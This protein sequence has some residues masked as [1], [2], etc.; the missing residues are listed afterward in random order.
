MSKWDEINFLFESLLI[1]FRRRRRFYTSHSRAD[2]HLGAS[3]MFF[4][5]VV[6]SRQSKYLYDCLQTDKRAS[7]GRLK[8]NTEKQNKYRE[9]TVAHTHATHQCRPNVEWKSS[10]RAAQ[11]LHGDKTYLHVLL[12]QRYA[13]WEMV[14]SVATKWMWPLTHGLASDV[15]P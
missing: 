9:S 3:P 14:R 6:W 1:D 11:K 10:R 7:F 15:D 2:F 8:T 5:L 4:F 12:L 13:M